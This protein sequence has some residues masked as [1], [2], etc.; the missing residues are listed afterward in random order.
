MSRTRH[1]GVPDG[2]L[3]VHREYVLGVR[4]E[5]DRGPDG[6]TYRFEAPDHRGAAFES[7][8]DAELYADVYFDTNGF[9]EADTGERGIPPEV[10]QAGRDTLAAYLLTRPWGSREWV[11]SYFGKDPATVERYAG[12]VRERAAEVRRGV[13]ERGIGPDRS[14]ESNEPDEPDD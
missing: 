13:R 5:V 2:S 11:A 4:I 3:S 1:S 12:W 8:D 9:R 14:D 10:V 6:E 7:A